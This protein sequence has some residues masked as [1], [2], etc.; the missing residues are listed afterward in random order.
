MKVKTAAKGTESIV[1]LRSYSGCKM[2]V[3]TGKNFRWI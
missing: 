3:K 2:L 1:F